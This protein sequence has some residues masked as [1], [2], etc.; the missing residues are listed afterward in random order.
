MTGWWD[1]VSLSV[2]SSTSLTADELNVKMDCAELFLPC[3]ETDR[4]VQ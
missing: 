3:R 2:I 4:H 1:K